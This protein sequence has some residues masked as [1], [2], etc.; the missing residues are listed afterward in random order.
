MTKYN[1]SNKNSADIII[2]KENNKIIFTNKLKYLGTYFQPD[3]KN[4]FDIK[5]ESN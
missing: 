4:N 1:K 5:K 2:D 3:I